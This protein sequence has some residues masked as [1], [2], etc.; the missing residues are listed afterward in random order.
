MKYLFTGQ[1]SNI[2]SSRKVRPSRIQRLKKIEEDYALVK[3]QVEEMAGFNELTQRR[4][5]LI[6][7]IMKARKR[8]DFVKANALFR[9]LKL[10]LVNTTNP[11]GHGID[12][13]GKEIGKLIKH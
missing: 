10:L 11:A 7:M 12:N 5:D 8:K 6:I 2:T 9:S 3:R 13:N 1:S 4:V